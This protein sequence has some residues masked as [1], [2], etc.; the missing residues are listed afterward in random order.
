MAAIVLLRARS[1]AR[2]AADLRAMAK[3]LRTQATLTRRALAQS[4]LQ[5][6]TKR[7]AKLACGG[8]DGPPASDEVLRETR[9]PRC[10]HCSCVDALHPSGSVQASDGLIKSTYRCGTCARF[11]LNVRKPFTLMWSVGESEASSDV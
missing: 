8:S 11:F 10:P 5:S 4:V 2:Q 3:D 1:L 6:P 9:D 7:L